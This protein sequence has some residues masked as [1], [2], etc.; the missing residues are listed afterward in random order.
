MTLMLAMGGIPLTAGFVGKVAVFQAAIDVDYLWLVIVGL[1]SATAGLFFYLRVIVLMYMQEPAR[2]EA[3]GA[4]MAVPQPTRPQQFTLA[5]SVL[6]T[7]FF[8]IVPWPLLEV[9]SD[10]IPF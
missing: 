7:I 2:A 9:A 8:G 10:A 4:A 3:P 1:L 6:V 5:S